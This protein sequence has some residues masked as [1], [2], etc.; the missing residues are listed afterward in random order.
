[1]LR[2]FAKIVVEENEGHWTG[3]FNDLTQVVIG[4][5][6]PSDAIRKLLEPLGEVNFDAEGI[7]TVEEGTRDGHLEFLMPLVGFRR[8]PVPSVN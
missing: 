7:V 4:G 5:E 1:M 3:W 8:I 2:A 6:W